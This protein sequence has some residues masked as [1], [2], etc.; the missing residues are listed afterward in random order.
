VDLPGERQRYQW[1]L[2]PSTGLTGVSD[3]GSVNYGARLA[4]AST[5]TSATFAGVL[6]ASNPVSM[7]QRLRVVMGSTAGNL[8]LQWA[9]NASN[10]TATTICA[11]A[12]LSARRAS[13]TG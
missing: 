3:E 1:Q 11:G 7:H 13:S 9:Q 6:D 10:A 4:D 8:R 12:K 5:P 2:A